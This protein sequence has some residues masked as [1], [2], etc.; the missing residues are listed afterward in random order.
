MNVKIGTEV[1][2]FLS[3]YIFSNLVLVAGVGG[4]GEGFFSNY[5]IDILTCLYERTLHRCRDGHDF[6]NILS[7]DC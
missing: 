3:G 4:L 7:L 1:E 5:V 2:Q 6:Y